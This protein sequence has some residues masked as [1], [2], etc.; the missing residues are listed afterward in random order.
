MIACHAWPVVAPVASVPDPQ[1]TL[2]VMITGGAPNSPVRHF[3][4][5]EDAGMRSAS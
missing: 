4:E 2:I 5:R 3:V 1:A